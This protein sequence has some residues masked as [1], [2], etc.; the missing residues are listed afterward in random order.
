MV[1]V[2]KF[3][4]RKF[5][6]PV[7]KERGNRGQV[8]RN[9]V[10]ELTETPA[11]V[12]RA[13]TNYIFHE[14]LGVDNKVVNQ[15]ANWYRDR[16]LKETSRVAAEIKYATGQ[17]PDLRYLFEAVDLFGGRAILDLAR[18]KIDSAKLL[19]DFDVHNFGG[20]RVLTPIKANV[21]LE[22]I[23]SANS[24]TGELRHI[25]LFPVYRGERVLLL[26]YATK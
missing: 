21:S 9:N 3:R 15:Y 6:K 25:G 12:I 5:L 22:T 10:R 11:D 8:I 4:S 26:D 13:G 2:Q 14:L 23:T 19:T 7:D 1:N 24:I 16:K 18:M 17:N 20:F